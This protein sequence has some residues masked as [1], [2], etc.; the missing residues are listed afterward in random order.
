MLLTETKIR[1]EA[2]S[3]NHLGYDVTC[4]TARLSSAWGDQGGMGLVTRERPVGWGV[5]SMRYHGPNVVICNIVVRLTRTLLLRTYLLPSMLE[6][7]PDLEESLQSLR[8]P[9]VRGDLN[10]DLNKARRSRSQ[11]VPYLLIIL[12]TM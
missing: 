7:L 1:S 8:E 4:L 5:E 2:Y 3:H 6:H 12:A 11:Y 10:V 9:I